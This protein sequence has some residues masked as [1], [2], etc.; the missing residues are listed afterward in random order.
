MDA[1]PKDTTDAKILAL[2]AQDAKTLKKCKR[3]VVVAEVLA[4]MLCPKLMLAKGGGPR[5]RENATATVSA[6][7]HAYEVYA[8]CNGVK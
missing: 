3:A 7:H 2:L 8:A 4:T 1:L 5:R 6:A